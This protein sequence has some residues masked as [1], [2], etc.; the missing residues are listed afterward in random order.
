[1]KQVSVKPF[2]KWAGG[3]GQLLSQLAAYYPQPLIN[4]RIKRYVEPFVGGGAVFFELV[5]RFH[6]EEVVLN[7]YNPELILTYA[8]IRDNPNDLISELTEMENHYLSQSDEEREKQFYSVRE[9]YNEEKQ[10]INYDTASSQW[11]P[12][13]A[14]LIFLN[15]TCFNGLYRLNSN[16]MFNVPF[17]SYK[18]PTI[19]DEKNIRNV[20]A[21]LESVT[22]VHGDFENLTDCIDDHTFVYMDPPYRPLSNSSSFNSY[23]KSPFNDDSQIRL[24]KWFKFLH[25][26]KKALLMLSNSD[27]KN[28]DKNDNFFDDLFGEFTIN[29]V[30]ATR[31][32]N[33]KGTGRGSITEILVTNELQLNPCAEQKLAY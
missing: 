20:S 18:K 19:C 26:E 8:T 17:G 15:K 31:A 5:S 12:H 2:L 23:S 13:A 11:I 29:R 33:S 24:A 16:G 1:M 14:K 27:P 6:F 10:I 22:L 3:K 7:D 25:Q 4:N 30:N 32:I 9:Q 28:I 21:A